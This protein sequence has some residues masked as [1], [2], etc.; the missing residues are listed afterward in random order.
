[1]EV[2]SCEFI[3]LCT[4]C[5]NSELSI[6][7][8]L[9]SNYIWLLF[10]YCLYHLDSL[11]WPLISVFYLICQLLTLFATRCILHSPGTP[12]LNDFLKFQVPTLVIN[13]AMRWTCINRF[14][15]ILYQRNRSINAT[16]ID[17]LTFLPV[18]YR[19]VPSEVTVL[20]PYLLLAGYLSKKWSIK[21]SEIEMH[22][23]PL[24]AL[25]VVKL[26]FHQNWSLHRSVISVLDDR[27]ELTHPS[28]IH[29]QDHE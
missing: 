14:E 18:I 28:W 23:Y 2:R 7:K 21:S 29:F 19:L 27:K 16:S 20:T 24:Q 17:N 13:K 3:C 5:I 6:E 9:Q 26:C 1:M 15:V 22:H 25:E 8:P 4:T 10:R 12:R 11:W